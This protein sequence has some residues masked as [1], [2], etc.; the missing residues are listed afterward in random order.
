MPR[1]PAIQGRLGLGVGIDLSWGAPVGFA[2]DPMRGDHV[3]DHVIRF[4][5]AHAETFHYVF[6][7]FQ[8][9][10]RNRLDPRDYFAAYDDLFSRIPSFPFRA[11]HQTTLNLG[12]MEAYDRGKVVDFTNTLIE[13]YHFVW[14]NED[15][16]LWSIHGKP[17]PYPLPPYL[18]LQGL[19]A[20]IRNTAEV[21]EKLLV[22]LL[23]EFPGFSDGTSFYLGHLHAYDFFRK[24]VEETNS[25]VTLDIGHLLSY[26]WMLGKRGEAL[27]DELE[28]LPLDHCF[29]IHLSGCEISGDSFLDYHHGVLLDEQLEL[30]RRLLPHCQNLSAIT[31]EDPK[32]DFEGR[33]VAE[34][35]HNFE[36][37]RYCVNLWKS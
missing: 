9:R 34:T 1:F 4:L 25:P 29:E 28:K 20:A 35:V 21:Q 11:F 14:V 24:V 26:Q 12:A 31:Y 37:L 2:H 36:R 15:L 22:P 7:S 18:T 13:R 30:L 32:F 17:L 8:P 16:G 3:T 33:F 27:Y 5:S 19:K 10:G 23:V 6:T